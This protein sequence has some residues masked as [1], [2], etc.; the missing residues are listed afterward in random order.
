[1]CWTCQVVQGLFAY[2][3]GYFNNVW[4][5]LYFTTMTCYCIDACMHR[6]VGKSD[7]GEWREGGKRDKGKTD[8]LEGYT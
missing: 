3:S 2:L 7:K 8:R 6:L 5:F 1:M 4:V